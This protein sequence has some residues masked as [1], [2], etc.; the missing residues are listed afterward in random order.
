MVNSETQKHDDFDH[1]TTSP[2]DKIDKQIRFLQTI[3]FFLQ[4]SNS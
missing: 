1:F 2:G 4:K 3:C